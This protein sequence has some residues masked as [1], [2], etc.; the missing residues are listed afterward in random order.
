MQ[1]FLSRVSVTEKQR[2]GKSLAIWKYLALYPETESH[3]HADV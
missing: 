1:D 3:Q 2:V